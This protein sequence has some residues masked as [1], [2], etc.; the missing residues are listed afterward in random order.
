MPSARSS[1]LTETQSR[2]YLI[3]SEW[4][5]PRLIPRAQRLAECFPDIPAD[6]RRAW[7]KEFDQVEAA[8]WKAAEAGGP[9]T[10]SFGVFANQLRK[11]FS[12]MS[13]EALSHAW[14]LVGYYTFHEGY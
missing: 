3:Y 5:P 2:A 11:T 14:T 13:D 7:M 9:R 1:T 10:G 6:T 4:G 12:F 8:I